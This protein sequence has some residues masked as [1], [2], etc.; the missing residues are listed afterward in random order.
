MLNK[1]SNYLIKKIIEIL[2]QIFTQRISSLPM[3]IQTISVVLFFNQIKYHKIVAKI[4][5]FFA[6]LT[7]GIYL[8]HN[9]NLIKKNIIVYLFRKESKS[10]SLNTIIILFLIRG[11]IVFVICI[12]I[13]YIRNLIFTFC[14]IKN[15]CIFIEKKIFKLFN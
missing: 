12:I 6:P 10:I 15:I 14:R 11:L 1:N 2:K 3:I 7:F 8:I 9:H 4:I 13:E 5:I